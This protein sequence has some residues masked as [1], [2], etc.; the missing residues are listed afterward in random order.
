MLFTHSALHMNS[1]PPFVALVQK[2]NTGRNPNLLLPQ[3]I[4][5]EESAAVPA[6]EEMPSKRTNK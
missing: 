1:S 4:G 5:E 6:L 2:R 3:Q